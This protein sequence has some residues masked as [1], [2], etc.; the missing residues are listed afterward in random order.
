M[1]ISVIIPVYN[2]AEL[3]R[4]AVDSV[5][6]QVSPADEII[7]VDDG[8][9]DPPE[10][11]LDG[12]TVHRRPHGGVSAARNSGIRSA[13]YDWLAFLDSDDLWKPKKLL[14]Q[15]QALAE[16]DCLVCFTDEEWRK[17]GLWKNQKLIHRKFG[18][19][20]FEKC[21]P[22]CIISPSSVVIHRSV[23]DK[24]GL[25]N[26]DYPAC[27]D[28]ELWLRICARMPVLYLPEKLIVKR[29][30]SWEQLSQQHSLDKYRI[31]ALV[32]R[33]RSGD[34]T[35]EQAQAAAVELRKKLGLYVTGCRKHG[36]DDEAEE[37]LRLAATVIEIVENEDKA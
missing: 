7:V 17:N 10:R 2:R 29:A 12:V 28:Y 3:V 22:R 15:R 16:S 24:V 4:E 36:R 18:G 23:F 32:E 1:K 9:T 8:S 11:G 26:E 6:R 5:L 21:L 33:L 13:R 30:G 37:I 35:S 27:E 31:R 19:F 20:I 25:F 14:R 34:L